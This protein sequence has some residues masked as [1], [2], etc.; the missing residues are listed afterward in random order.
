MGRCIAP[1]SV[2]RKVL[3]KPLLHRVLLFHGV[4]QLPGNVSLFLTFNVATS[5]VKKIL[6]HNT[7]KSAERALCPELRNVLDR[8]S[9]RAHNSYFNGADGI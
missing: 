1:Y 2:R 4:T 8:E 9:K 3:H 5:E 7:L 6:K